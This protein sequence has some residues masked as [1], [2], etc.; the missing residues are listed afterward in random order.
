MDAQSFLTYI[1]MAYEARLKRAL[2]HGVLFGKQATYPCI[3]T[4]DIETLIHRFVF[5]CVC[6]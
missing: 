2:K 6:M 3:V 4:I 1:H 5:V